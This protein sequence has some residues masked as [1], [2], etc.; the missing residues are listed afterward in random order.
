MASEGDLSIRADVSKTG[1][2]VEAGLGRPFRL[3]TEDQWECACAADSS[4][5]FRWGDDLPLTCCPPGNPD[6]VE[7]AYPLFAAASARD[8]DKRSFRRARR[9]LRPLWMERNSVGTRPRVAKLSR[10]Q[11]HRRLHGQAPMLSLIAWL[12]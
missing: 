11:R 3:P 4:T 7:E 2:E 12:S 6:A 10:E 9:S 5:L 8:R 1:A